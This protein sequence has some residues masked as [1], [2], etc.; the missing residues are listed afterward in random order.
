[1]CM[2]GGS[3]LKSMA[4][5]ESLI[6]EAVSVTGESDGLMLSAIESLETMPERLAAKSQKFYNIK[7]QAIAESK[8]VKPKPPTMRELYELHMELLKWL[9]EIWLD[10]DLK[11]IMTEEEYLEFRKAIE[12]SW[13]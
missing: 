8:M 4:M 2:G 5:M 11:E 12:E 7:P 9:D 6:L 1:M 10:G 13:L 3:T